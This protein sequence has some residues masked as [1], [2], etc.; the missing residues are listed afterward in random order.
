MHVCV[1]SY[2]D[3]QDASLRYTPLMD[4]V[5]RGSVDVVKLLLTNG[6]DA[7]ACDHQVSWSSMALCLKCQAIDHALICSN[8]YGHELPAHGLR[9]SQKHHLKPDFAAGRP[10]LLCS[11]NC[12]CNR[13]NGSCQAATQTRSQH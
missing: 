13:S 2:S 6:A 8:M 10:Q 3:L 11:A 9:V 5:R 7:N 12:S 4:A 1:L